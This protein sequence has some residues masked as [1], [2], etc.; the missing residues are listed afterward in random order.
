M[1]NINL[2][3]IGVMEKRKTIRSYLLGIH[4]FYRGAKLSTDFYKGYNEG[5]L[6]ALL[7]N[8]LL[9]LKQINIIKRMLK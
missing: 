9:N 4:D 3:N 2:L 8:Y 6:D 7:Q 1:P 5:Y